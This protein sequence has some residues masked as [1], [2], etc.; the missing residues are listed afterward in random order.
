META[1]TKIREALCKAEFPAV[2]WSG[3]KDS[4]LL[5]TLAREINP[6]IPVIWFRSS[7]RE[8][9]AR[10]MIMELH[11]DVWNWEPSDVYVLPN[12]SGLSLVREQSFGNQ[13]FPVVLDVEQGERCIGDVLPSRTL[14]LFPHFDTLLLGYKDSDYHWT[15]GGSGFCPADGWQLGKAKVFAPLR[16]LSDE[17]VWSA[18]KTMGVPYDIERYEGGGS[19][20]DCMSACTQCLQPGIGKVFCPKQQAEIDRVAWSPRDSLQAFRIR[21][22]FREN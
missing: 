8:T 12:D 15:L 6:A 7:G 20:P 14:Q 2:L 4:Q 13:R 1:R 16:H 5:L 17:E 19:D 10:R 11:L 18:I 3:G 22:G 21:F 9:F